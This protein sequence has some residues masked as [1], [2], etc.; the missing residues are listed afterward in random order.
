MFFL[1]T[2]CFN[3]LDP[4]PYKAYLG[5]GTYETCMFPRLY[6]NSR[7]HASFQNNSSID[8]LPVLWLMCQGRAHFHE[9]ILPAFGVAFQK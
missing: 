3:T 9:Q 2:G 5:S 1:H 6:I 7:L 4:P 8:L